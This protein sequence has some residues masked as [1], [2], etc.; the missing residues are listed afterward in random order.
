MPTDTGLFRVVSIFEY[1]YIYKAIDLDPSGE[2]EI[3]FLHVLLR[4]SIVYKVKINV[5]YCN[6]IVHLFICD[7]IDSK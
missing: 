6:Q 2:Y 7:S 3:N 5:Y 4:V 1:M